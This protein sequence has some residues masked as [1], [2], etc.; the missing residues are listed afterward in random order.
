MLIGG[1]ESTTGGLVA[2][3][4]YLMRHPENKAKLKAAFQEK[5]SD[6][7]EKSLKDQFRE[8]YLWNFLRE[9]L[10][11]NTPALVHNHP[12]PSDVVLPCSDGKEYKFDSNN[13]IWMS[14]YLLQHD[15]DYWENPSAFNPD[16][17]KKDPVPGA[18]FPFGIGA[19]Q[20]PGWTYSVREIGLCLKILLE[21]FEFEFED[22]SFQIQYST[23]VTLRPAIPIWI[24]ISLLRS[25]K[26]LF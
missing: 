13:I 2:A 14:Q 23:A 11:R 6:G 3:F 24:K 1:S 4:Y 20:C 19:R 25:S 9:V 15:P 12:I 21:N 17:W 18:F 7:T 5:N 16:R 22:P 10:R 26:S 8:G